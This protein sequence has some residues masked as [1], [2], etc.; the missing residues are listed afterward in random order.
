MDPDDYLKQKQDDIKTAMGIQPGS[1]G[2]IAFD[3]YLGLLE[4]MPNSQA[5]MILQNTH[6]GIELYRQF[7]DEYRAIKRMNINFDNQIDFRGQEHI[8]V[9]GDFFLAIFAKAYAQNRHECYKN[10]QSMVQQKLQMA[11]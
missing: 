5:T 9:N 1:N 4:N 8:E 10:I 11:N 7:N 2:R 3:E 6:M